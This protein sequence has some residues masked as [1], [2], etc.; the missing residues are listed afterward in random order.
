MKNKV[1]VFFTADEAYAPFLAAAINSLVKNVS[2]DREYSVTVLHEDITHESMAKILSLAKENVEISFIPM[3]EGFDAITDKMSN[4][5]RCDYF[6]LTIYFRLFIPEMFPDIDKCIYIDSDTVLSADIAELY[7]TD[8][9]D[10]LFG[11]C[12]DKSVSDVPE[13][14]AY[15][16]N[17]VGVN[18]YKYVNSGVLLMNSKKLREVGFRDHFLSLLTTYAFDCIAP[19]QDYINAIAKNRIRHLPDAWDTMPNPN[20]PEST[21]AKLIHY[22]LFSKP[23]CY[24]KIQYEDI[25]WH[26]AEDS[27]FIDEI[28]AYKSAYGDDKKAADASCLSLL[29]RRGYEISES[30]T[31]FRTA[32]ANGVKIA[33]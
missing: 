3:K 11:A 29:V 6:T 31:T 23:W 22:N 5:L 26:Y 12:A 15:M 28:R 8:I 2:P 13:L 17:A 4:R 19:D 18:R 21:D 25:F 10:D 27:G 9:G 32:E 16:E 20:A 7:D 1:P 24:D 14:A 33:L 30:D